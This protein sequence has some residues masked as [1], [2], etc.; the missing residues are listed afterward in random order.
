[1][2]K[3]IQRHDVLG[4]RIRGMMSAL[5]KFDMSDNEKQAYEDLRIQAEEHERKSQLFRQQ[6]FIFMR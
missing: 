3:N 4:K 6:T 2:K 1:M 5:Y